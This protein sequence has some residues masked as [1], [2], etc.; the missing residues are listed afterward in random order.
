MMKH[1]YPF[2]RVLS[3]LAVS[4]LAACASPPA[5]KAP[6]PA[7]RPPLTWQATLPHAGSVERLS[8]WWRQLGDPALA[9]L[10]DAAQ[11]SSPSVAAASARIA[12]ARAPLV[13]ADAQLN[14]SLNVAANASRARNDPSMP[15]TSSLGLGLQSQWEIDLFGRNQATRDAA[16]ARLDGATAGWHEARVAVAAELGQTYTALRACEAQRE[17]TALDTRSRA[18]TARLTDLAAKAG[19][20]ASA[21]AALANASAAQGRSLLTQQT[22]QCELLIKALVSLTALE[23]PALRALIASG[24]ARLAQPAG[25]RVPSVPAEALA[26]RPDVAAAERE[27]LAAGYEVQANLALWKPRISLSGNIGAARTLVMGNSTDGT[28]WSIGPLTVSLPILDGGVRQANLEAAQ[29]RV[30]EARSAYAARLRT[31]IREVE[32]S[33]VN[34]ESTAARAQDAQA[35]ADNFATS[36]K[37]AQARYQ[38]GFGTLFELEDARRSA[39]LA[40]SALIDLRRE[41]TTAWISLYRALGGGWQPEPP[42]GAAKAPS[43]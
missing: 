13:L 4:T 23:E 34:L 40:Q 22:A 10:I 33:L 32:E 24:S 36:L 27:L 25:I 18:E 5:Q 41:R 42:T 30:G 12:G 7:S 17:Q 26:Q 21:S 6:D 2:R 35:A 19:L 3:V 9:A 11:A 28:T 29:A 20:Q 16:R 8:D 1:P 37:A 43:P 39:L 31:A 15:V 38:G 14:P